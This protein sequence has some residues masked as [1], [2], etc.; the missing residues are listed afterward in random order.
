LPC[1]PPLGLPV[2][3]LFRRCYQE[4]RRAPGDQSRRPAASATQPL[5]PVP[6]P[7]GRRPGPIVQFSATWTG[8]AGL[9]APPVSPAGAICLRD[10]TPRPACS[11]LVTRLPYA[12]V[13]L[14]SSLGTSEM[15]D[16]AS[17]EVL[18][19]PQVLPLGLSLSS[20]AFSVTAHPGSLFPWYMRTYC[21]FIA[22]LCH[23]SR[24][25]QHKGNK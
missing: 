14:L 24:Y 19:P 22:L 2:Q 9:T 17:T 8:E 10:N 23:H 1:G 12:S 6:P 16:L 25:G 3:P 13:G 18:H 11:P 5:I 15:A 20:R 4:S 7:V 21:R